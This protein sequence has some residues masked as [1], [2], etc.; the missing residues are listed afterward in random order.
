M[1]TAF[2]E[3]YDELMADVDYPA[4]AGF[5]AEILRQ[6]GI[7]PGSK[8]CECAC[9][10]G[11]LT[12]PLRRAGFVMTGVD[13][14]QDMLWI[15]SQK[16][17]RSGAAIPFICQD[18]RAL[19]LHRPMDAVLATCDGVNYLT[20]NRDVEQFFRAAW[21]ALRPGGALVFDVSTPDKLQNV[22]GDRTFFEE[23]D[24]VSYVWQN[25]YH[26]KTATVEM[27]LS[28]FLREENG[29]YRRIDERQVQKAHSQET[30]TELLQVCGFSA[31]RVMGDHKLAEPGPHEQRWHIAARK[32]EAEQEG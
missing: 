4:W 21:N 14:S 10:T 12:L 28:F 22:L 30:L 9:G 23:T 6:Y 32:P 11:S 29:L 5:Y 31:I 3:I 24:R 8:V 18:M 25:Q 26:P 27:A 19:R 1:Y 17:R 13:L 16:A 2:A 15:A 20:G 7:G